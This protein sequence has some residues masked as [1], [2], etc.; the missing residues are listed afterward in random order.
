MHPWILFG[1]ILQRAVFMFVTISF[2]F[3]MRS[4]NANGF[5]QRQHHQQQHQLPRNVNGFFASRWT[6]TALTRNLRSISHI[7]SRSIH[8]KPPYTTFFSASEAS[9]STTNHNVPRKFKPFPFEYHQE[10]TV[11]V[12]NLN[13][14][15]VGVCRVP[16]STETTT[17]TEEEST[18]SSLWV[19]LVPNVIPGELIRIR[20]YRNFPSHSDADLMEILEPQTQYRISTPK[21]SLSGICGGCQYQHMTIE[22][23]R[24]WKTKHVQEALERIT[25][26]TTIPIVQPTLGNDN[27]WNY[28]SKLTPHYDAPKKQKQD[29]LTTSTTIYEIG[30]MGFQQ[31]SS[32]QLIDV[33]Y[34]PIATEAINHHWSQMRETLHHKAQ[35]GTLS[36]VKKGATLLLLDTDDGV[37]T[38]HNQYV[39]SYLDILMNDD[40]DDDNDYDSKTS[41]T[42]M[43]DLS[44][45]SNHHRRRRRLVFRFKAGNFF[46]VNPTMVPVMVDCMVQY[47][48]QKGTL[49][50]RMTHVLDCYCGS[51]LFAI[52]MA[53]HV[54]QCVGI[55]V[56]EKA[57]E[58][59]TMNARLNNVTNCVFIAASAEAIFSTNTHTCKSTSLNASTTKTTTT[60][61]TLPSVDTFPRETTVVVL[62][63]PRKGCSDE[64]IEQLLEYGP[65]RIAYMS[66][67]V[68]TQARDIQPMMAA[69]YDLTFVQPL[70][71]FPQT[72]HIEC[73][74]ILEKKEDNNNN[75]R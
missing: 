8:N 50:H 67:N 23:Q 7:A 11:R 70:D 25:K 5:I 41:N 34:C 29:S 48:L 73:L 45:Q 24:Y 46:Q 65:Q 38:D 52:A 12:D 54:E 66:C 1:S 72:R 69:G 18:S 21:C 28:R 53:S 17:L 15:G 35:T 51:G 63:P 55:E 58:E 39:S 16:I 33:P 59:A 20:I 74:M 10:L 27:I 49:T 22:S 9:F 71:L 47:A 13:N 19:V 40:N 43:T 68:V 44:A 60:T 64:F 3:R 14:M 6:N 37:V 56:N 4:F 30:P 26:L 2:I 62:D 42:Q 61:T 75:I 31:Q 57:I 36:S 32:R